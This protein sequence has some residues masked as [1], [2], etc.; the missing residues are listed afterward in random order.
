MKKLSQYISEKLIINK[1][2]KI[3]K[4]PDDFKDNLHDIIRNKENIFDAEYDYNLLNDIFNNLI[5]DPID[6]IIYYDKSKNIR[7]LDKGDILCSIKCGNHELS[8]KN[9]YGRNISICEDDNIICDMSLDWHRFETYVAKNII[10][11][12]FKSKDTKHFYLENTKMNQTEIEKIFDFL[13]KSKINQ[14][15]FDFVKYNLDNFDIYT[16][17]ITNPKYCNKD[18]YPKIEMI[19]FYPLN[20]LENTC[21]ILYNWGLDKSTYNYPCPNKEKFIETLN[22]FLEN[23]VD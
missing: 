21:Y 16:G 10:D 6:D 2:Y 11:K 7:N 1:N 22:E 17:I 14:L 8:I 5:H 4:L 18:G 23:Y 13:E 19:G 15:Q 20:D 12:F 9:D 3:H